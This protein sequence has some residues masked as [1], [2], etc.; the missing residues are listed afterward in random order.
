MIHVFIV[1]ALPAVRAG[2]AALVAA[3]PECEV[4]GTAAPAPDLID[5]IASAEAD[6]VLIEADPA[7]MIETVME[8]T[9]AAPAA[10]VILVGAPPEDPRLQTA[11]AGRP[12]GYLP[13]EATGEEILV[14]I[15]AVAGG[16]IA[17]DPSFALMPTSAPSAGLDAAARAGDEEALTAREQ[18]VLQ[19]IAAGLP[20]K[21][22]AARLGISEHTV[23]FHVASIFSKLGAASR[24][25]AVRLGARR[26]LVAL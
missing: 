1:S 8:I 10:R 13:R 2:L 20:N 15:Q 12:W 16:L 17:V 21:T 22:I 25:E 18:E 4:V 14:A 3:G 5:R 24:A 26:G 6:V 19:L 11:L 7:D 9:A 23:K